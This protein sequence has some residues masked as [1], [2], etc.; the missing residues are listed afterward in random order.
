MAN[1]PGVN[2]GS[3]PG[4]SNF[5]RFVAQIGVPAALAFYVLAQLGPKIDHGIAV[6]DHVDA[7]LQFLAARGCAP[8]EIGR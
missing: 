1:G 3:P 8:V 7:E 5:G 6:A 2:G 4:W